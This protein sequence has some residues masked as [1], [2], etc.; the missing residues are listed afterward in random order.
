MISKEWKL[1]PGLC[2]GVVLLYMGGPRDLS[3]VKPF[4]RELFRDRDLIA[5]PGG[6]WLQPLLAWIIVTART[7][8]VRRY[9]EEIGGGSPLVET[10]TRQARLLEAALAPAGPFV[11]DLAMR[12]SPPWT[13]EALA[14]LRD[15]GAEQLIALPLYPQFSAAT[16]GSSFK[17]L[18]DALD[19]LGLDLPLRRIPSFFDHAG[20]LAALSDTV[21]RGLNEAGPDPTVVFS[22]HSLPQSFIERGDPYKQQVEA[23]VASVVERLE[24]RDWHLG[25]Q[26]RS[27]PVRWLEPEVTRLVDDL[28]DRGRRRLCVVPVSFV[29]D[30]L[31]TLH[32]L[33]IRFKQHCLERGAERFVRAPALGVDPAFINALK[34]MVVDACQRPST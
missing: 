5:L 20:Y 11:V 32:E 14:R 1:D 13:N 25:F 7:P 22:A 17:A 15:R 27:G 30:H 10:T 29:S 31:E 24:L 12:Y 23:T 34:D 16:T 21:A 4:L 28:L 19:A 18:D 6:P 3:Q 9:Y 2:T 8:K 26:S 33:D